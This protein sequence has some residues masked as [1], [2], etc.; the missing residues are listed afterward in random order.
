MKLYFKTRYYLSVMV[1]LGIIAAVSYAVAQPEVIILNQAE[2]S[3]KMRAP[4]EFT[5]ETHM[6]NYECLDCHHAYEDGENVLDEGDLEE[7]NPDILCASCH[8]AGA[9]LNAQKAFHRQ[10]MGCH[11]KERKAGN[12]TGP[13]LCGECHIKGT[14]S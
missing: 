10:C 14:D 1:F 11:I 8:D 4:V 6:E 7:G 9:A 5:H 12:G 3:D 2:N 13:E